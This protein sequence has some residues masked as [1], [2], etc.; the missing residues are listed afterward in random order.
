MVLAPAGLESEHCFMLLLLGDTSMLVFSCELSD[1]FGKARRDRFDFCYRNALGWGT[2]HW[3]YVLTPHSCWLVD[4][5]V[6]VN[7]SQHLHWWWMGQGSVIEHQS[8]DVHCTDSR[9]GTTGNSP[10]ARLQCTCCHILLPAC[11][12]GPCCQSMKRRKVLGL[13]CLT[14]IFSTSE[15]KLLWVLPLASRCTHWP[16]RVADHHKHSGPTWSFSVTRGKEPYPLLKHAI[17]H[18][19]QE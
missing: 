12:L 13:N 1:S 9:E 4:S 17:Q 16:A 6:T 14:F 19:L 5:T 15:T 7:N 10:G 3:S 8:F 2:F 18:R 11:L